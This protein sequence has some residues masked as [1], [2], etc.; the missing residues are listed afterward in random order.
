MPISTS[1]PLDEPPETG[2]RSFWQQLS[3]P[4]ASIR[5]PGARR[6]ARLLASL[7]IIIILFNTIGAVVSWYIVGVPAISGTL[8]IAALALTLAYVLSRTAFYRLAATLTVLFISSIPFAPILFNSNISSGYVFRSLIWIVMTV[9]LGKLFLSIRGLVFI[10][11][12]NLL[13]LVLVLATQPST[14]PSSSIFLVSFVTVISI[15]ILVAAHHRNQV[16]RD[17]LEEL[18]TANGELAALR[19]SL[20]QQVEARTAELEET[21]NFLNTILDSLPNALFVKDAASFNYIHW[22]KAAEALMGFDRKKML[23]RGDEELFPKE[24]AGRLNAEDR[25][26]ASSGETLDRSDEIL[27]NTPNP[28]I[29]HTQKRLITSSE[30]APKYILGI[31][32]DITDRRQAEAAKARTEALFRAL[33]EYS[34][35]AIILIDPHDPNVSWPILDCNAVACEMNGYTREELIG[36]S[37]DLLNATVGDAAERTA[38]LQQL[39]A[40][41]NLKLESFHRHK[42]GTIFPIEVSTSLITVNGQELV[43]GIDRDIT[44]RKNTEAALEESEALFRVL[45]DRSPNAI[46]LLDTNNPDVFSYIVDCNSMACEMNGYRREELIGRSIEDIQPAPTTLEQQ[47]FIEEQLEESAHAKFEM[48]HKRKDGTLY[49]V[50]VTV[51]MVTIDERAL[52]LAVDHDITERKHAEE[53]LRRQNTYLAAVHETTLGLLSRTNVKTVLE[54]ILTRAAQLAETS[55]GY[56]YLPRPNSDGPEMEVKVGIGLGTEYM[57]LRIR[58]GEGI[59]GQA[60][61]TELPQIVN[62]YD[63][64]PGRHSK[65]EQGDFYSIIAVPLI[66]PE[67]GVIGVIGLAYDQAS[68]RTFGDEEVDLL[69][70]LAQLSTVALDNAQMYADTIEYAAESAALYRAAIRLLHPGADLVSLARQIA[71]V[72]TREFALSNCSV[73]LIDETGQTLQRIANAGDF[74]VTGAATLPL[75]GSGLT[76][77]AARS[78]EGIYAS[79]VTTDQR[80]L[81]KDTRTR[82][83]LVMPLKNQDRVIGVLDLQSP[84]PNA[85]DE[86]AQRILSA[87]AKHAELTLENA[88]LLTDLSQAYHRL[89]EDQEQ[90]LASEKMASLGRLTAGIAHEMNTPLAAVRSALAEL[91]HLIAEYQAAIGDPEITPDDHHEIALDMQ[92][93]ARL[94][95]SSA[96]RAASFVRSIKS[97]TRET[98][99]GERMRFKVV[100]VVEDTLHLLGHALR[101]GKCTISFEHEGEEDELIGAPGRLGQ[102]VTNLITNAI[103]ACAEKGGGPIQ[104]RLVRTA[105]GLDLQVHDWGS[106]IPPELVNKIFEPMF[107]TKPFGQGTGLG[108][109]IIHDIV[110][111]DFGGT[112]EVSSQPGQGATFTVHFPHLQEV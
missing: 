24:L 104:V 41:G 81:A 44:A 99:P 32:E 35:D 65:L 12:A 18:T 80:Y 105:S 73:L 17:R 69:T 92:K 19:A 40:A 23:G 16:E 62:D 14:E 43:L 86:R 2:P 6:Q 36:Q 52:F 76:V 8:A 108:L 26:I 63:H 68:G 3:E 13:A 7:L 60:W 109:T 11:A 10:I 88:R 94:A 98:S 101:H 103:D 20:E 48:Y 74:Q 71:Q 97:Q 82:S 27:T 111:G 39:R 28:R 56:I 96:E 58:P 85:F 45:F 30:G 61:Q 25:M 37:I 54:D 4:S 31:S 21:K 53:T 51:T 78:G 95:G 87:F 90:L 46:W 59:G 102:V 67:Q 75:T 72:V 22:N 5:E 100:P 110:T 84:E 1:P 50:E 47:K 70:R 112:V 91:D 79:D 15:L 29:L 83:E 64:W 33:F 93:T 77:A 66:S 106:G 42:N 57:G 89:Q 55:H 49:L 107:T 9:L 38:Y 34:P